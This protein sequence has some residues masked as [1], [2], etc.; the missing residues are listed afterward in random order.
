MPTECAA[1][2]QSWGP[3]CHSWRDMS[4]SVT[5]F[6]APLGVAVTPKPPDTAFMIDG[7]LIMESLRTGT[8]LEGLALTVRKI[9]R[10]RAQGSTPSQPGIW[11]VLDFEADE[12]GADGLARAFADVL[13]EGPGW[14]LNFQS[15]T[16]SFVVFPGKI[17]RYPRG[18]AAGRADAQAYGRRLG[19]PEPQL[20]WTV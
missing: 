18:D 2:A 7:T 6:H 3:S 15:P 16:A 17:F 5:D 19:I 13:E 9:S 1:V 4:L 14:Y 11:T 10:Y 12:A 20:D 8:S